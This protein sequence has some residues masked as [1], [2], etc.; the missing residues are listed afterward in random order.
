MTLIGVTFD[1]AHYRVVAKYGWKDRYEYLNAQN[2]YPFAENDGKF[3]TPRD[4]IRAAK[5]IVAGD[6]NGH[7]TFAGV[8]KPAPE[9]VG[10]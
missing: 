1:G 2:T 10:V 3:D 7:T 5:Q 4:V 8:I 9:E 6:F